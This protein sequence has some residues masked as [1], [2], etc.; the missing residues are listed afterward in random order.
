MKGVVVSGNGPTLVPVDS[1]GTP[2]A[3]AVLWMDERAGSLTGEI[4]NLVGEYIPPNF[5]LSR[6][7]WFKKNR[8]EVYKNSSFFIS[9]PEYVAYKLTGNRFTTLPHS[10]FTSF[11]WSQKKLAALELD[12]LKFPPFLPISEVYGNYKP[13]N[14][15]SDLPNGTVLMI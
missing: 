14:I 9:C 4:Q 15:L 6:V 7:Y 3:N 8:P 5:F 1:E 10:G 13:S 11:Y 2:L 12:P